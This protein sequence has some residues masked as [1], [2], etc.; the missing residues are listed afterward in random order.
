MAVVV[1]FWPMRVFSTSGAALRNPVGIKHTVVEIVEKTTW[2]QPG[3]PALFVEGA[4]TACGT[5]IEFQ[6]HDTE[7]RRGVPR[8][9]KMCER[10]AQTKPQDVTPMIGVSDAGWSDALGRLAGTGQ[11]TLLS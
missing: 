7:V 8:P 3:G 5:T 6:L 2:D 4:R 1:V 9:T 11:G 10:C